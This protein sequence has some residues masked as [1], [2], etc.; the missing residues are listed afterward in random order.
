VIEDSAGLSPCVFEGALTGLSHQVFELRKDLLDRI[1][2]RAIGRQ[3]EDAGACGPDGGSHGASLV[4]AEIVENDNVVWLECRDQDLGDVEAEQFTVDRA[5]DDKGRID[6]IM[7]QR[8]EKGH[9]LPMPIRDQRSQSLAARSPAPEWRHVGLDPG[10]VDEDQAL[11]I[12]PALVSLP[13]R[14]L[15]RDVR[16][17]L[18][19]RND[20]FF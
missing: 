17:G 10:L 4:T 6:A 13:A 9:G 20:G 19:R 1:E 11:A 7:T 5:I 14:S 12:D 2:V 18:L 3:E 8:G 16:P 15:A